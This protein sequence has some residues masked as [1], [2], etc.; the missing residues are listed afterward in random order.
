VRTEDAADYFEIDEPSPYMLMVA[1]GKRNRRRH[2]TEEQK[3]TV[4]DR[5]AQRAPSDIPAV[6]PVEYSARIQTLHAET[7]ACYHAFI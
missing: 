1:D 5:Q 4:R 7:D 6:T 2:S 3:K